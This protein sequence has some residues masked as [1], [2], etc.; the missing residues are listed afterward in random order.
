M[1]FTYAW[2]TFD[3]SLISSMLIDLSFAQTVKKIAC[4]QYAVIGLIE[5]IYDLIMQCVVIYIAEGYGENYKMW[6]VI[7][8]VH[9][10]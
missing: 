3:Y 9:Y 2:S 4:S 7:E 8:D 1:E 6:H 10:I 5:K